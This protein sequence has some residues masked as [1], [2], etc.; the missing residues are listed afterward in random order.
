MGYPPTVDNAPLSGAVG[1][2]LALPEPRPKLVPP[3][4][5]VTFAVG[6]RCRYDKPRT[7]VQSQLHFTSDRRF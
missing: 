1:E 3:D 2:Q 7:L 4:Y 5:P 6:T